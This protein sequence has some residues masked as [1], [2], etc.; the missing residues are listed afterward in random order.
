MLELPQ[1]VSVFAYV[2]RRWKGVCLLHQE[3]GGKR[4]CQK[5]LTAQFRDWK[6]KSAT[7]YTNMVV[8]YAGLEV[9]MPT[10]AH[11]AL[12]YSWN[13]EGYSQWHF[14]LSPAKENRML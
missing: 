7:S 8:R 1:A 2:Y 5:P 11:N 6:I 3:W 9:I 14:L 10:P 13:S 12:A 4:F